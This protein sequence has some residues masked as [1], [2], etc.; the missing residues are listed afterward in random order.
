VNKRTALAPKKR[1]RDPTWWSEAEALVWIA[2]RDA[3]IVDKTHAQRG[4][5]EASLEGEDAAKLAFVSAAMAT[6]Y[7]NHARAAPPSVGAAIADS[8]RELGEAL[9]AS[10]IERSPRGFRSKEV[11]TEWPGSGSGR[12]P[13]W[14]FD[15]AVVERVA[16]EIM[17]R[18]RAAFALPKGRDKLNFMGCRIAL[19]SETYP[20][21]EREDARWIAALFTAAIDSCLLKLDAPSPRRVAAVTGN[22]RGSPD[23]RARRLA[24]VRTWTEKGRP[25]SSQ[26]K[27]AL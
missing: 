6:A 12:A 8:A 2:T 22:F 21:S 15:G 5:R 23:D 18:P 3:R 24:N 7:P 26:G 25:R 14:T 13:V 1:A 17:A 9:A 11:R 20:N 16:A 10:R 4:D 19:L 27:F